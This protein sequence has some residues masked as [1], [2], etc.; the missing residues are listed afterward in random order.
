[1]PNAVFVIPLYALDAEPNLDDTPDSMKLHFSVSRQVASA[2]AVSIQISKL[3][4]D[5]ETIENWADTLI[6][7]SETFPT[8]EKAFSKVIAQDLNERL[9]KLK[10]S[11]CEEVAQTDL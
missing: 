11:A 6:S 8:L 5:I 4:L 3:K 1:M 9:P 10:G 2:L 7:L